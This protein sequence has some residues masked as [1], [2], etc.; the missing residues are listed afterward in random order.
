MVS[1]RYSCKSRVSFATYGLALLALSLLPGPLFAQGAPSR[2]AQAQYRE[3]I[4]KGLQEYQL[5]HWSEARVF[6]TDAHTLW[7]NARTF[8][9]LGM[10][11]YEARSYVEAIDFLEQALVNQTQPLTPKLAEEAKGIL[12]QARRFV[13]EVKLELEPANATVML[14]DKPLVRREHGEILVDPGEHQLDV[15]APGYRSMQRTLIAQ[16]GQPVH[17][18][19]Q[20]VSLHAE[21]EREASTSNSAGY[22]N[23]SPFGGP[24]EEQPEK[25][26]HE[27]R[28]VLTGQH[29][30]AAALV[31]GFGFASMAAG[32]AMFALRNDAR[33]TLWRE[34]LQ[35]DSTA[36]YYDPNVLQRYRLFGAL[37]WVGIGL[38]SA[39]LSLAEYLWLPDHPSIPAWAWVLGG[40]GV[41]LAVTAVVLAVAETHCEVTDSFAVCQQAVA[42][43]WFAPLLAVPALPFLTLPLFYAIRDRMV[44]T[45]V[46]AALLWNSTPGGGGPELM[47]R[48]SF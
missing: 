9:G 25:T 13:S 2:A 43:P 18:H 32:W 29:P 34:G 19:V 36:I 41:A 5:G 46:K 7:P 33:L 23:S 16:G 24:L 20:L 1:E 10:T 26:K 38:G 42:D 3:L 8:R 27:T 44:V 14:D 47:I 37:S 17:A 21:P 30:L 45:E 12:D 28:L 31:G 22:D 39:M 15:S 4:A 40:V 35:W 11:C 48:G 6:F